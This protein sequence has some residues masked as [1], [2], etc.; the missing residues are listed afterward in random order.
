LHD[1]KSHSDHHHIR[2]SELTVPQHEVNQADIEQFSGL[3]NNCLCKGGISGYMDFQDS[4]FYRDRNH[5]DVSNWWTGS[6]VVGALPMM[7]SLWCILF[8]PT[9][10]LLKLKPL[11]KASEHMNPSE[12]TNADTM[13]LI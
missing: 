2:C 7:G 13:W 1:R 9:Q 12:V 11:W 3:Y 5:F 8:P 10:L 6:A 4:E